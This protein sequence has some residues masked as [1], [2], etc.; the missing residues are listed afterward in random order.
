[1]AATRP[2]RD[3][4]LHHRHEELIAG[5]RRSRPSTGGKIKSQTDDRPVTR[6]TYPFELL[7]FRRFG[8]IG[9]AVQ[10]TL[11]AALY[12]KALSGKIAPLTAH[13]P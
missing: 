7:H 1:M 13:A 11:V 6:S 9:P 10:L 4:H 5:K 3:Q 12:A 8:P 2:P